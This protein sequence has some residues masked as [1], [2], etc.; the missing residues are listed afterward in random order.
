[1]ATFAY[2]LR[3]AES[4]ARLATATP[5]TFSFPVPCGRRTCRNGTA[6]CSG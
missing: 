1:M 5:G 4:D 3:L 6:R 2:E